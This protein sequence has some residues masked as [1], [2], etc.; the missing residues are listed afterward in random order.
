MRIVARRVLRSLPILLA[1]VGA[2]HAKPLQVVRAQNPD[3][4]LPE[5]SAAKAKDLIQK[6]IQALGGKAFLEVRDQSAQ[7]RLGQWDSKGQLSGYTRLYDFWKFPDK[8][9]TE[10]SKKRNIIDVYRGDKGWT[11]D[12]GGVGDLPATQTESFQEGLK[13]DVFLLF[14]YRLNEEGMVF[15]WGGS[16]LLDM[17]RVDWIEVMDSD[18]RTMRIALD[19]S[20]HLPMRA[21]YLTRNKE[22]RVKSEEEELFAN[23]YNIQGV[24]TPLQFTR[25]RNGRQVYQAFYE[26]VQYNTGLADDFFTKESLDAVWAKIGK[27]K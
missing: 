26:E 23:Y 16:D 9:R 11:L 25:I 7:V 18:R 27:K 12:K 15:R 2:W 5:Q 13:K 1:I 10:Y 6:A 17:K 22:T 19:A 24:M 4:L 3:T 8:N 20:T 21:V 14:R